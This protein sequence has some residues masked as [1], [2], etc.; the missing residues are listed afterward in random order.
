MFY[1]LIFILAI[2]VSFMVLAISN[3]YLPVFFCVHLGWHLAPIT[4]G[5]DGCSFTGVCP[6]CGEHILQDGQGNWF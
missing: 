5:F 4:Q 3:K 2:L 1:I 6:R